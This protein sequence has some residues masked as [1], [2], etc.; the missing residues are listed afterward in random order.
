MAARDE[1]SK[2]L[3]SEPGLDQIRGD[4]LGIHALTVSRS[5]LTGQH[6]R[7]EDL[8]YI[9]DMDTLAK[10]LTWARER[11]GLTQGAL[12]KLSGV[13]QST[14]GNLEAGL[15]Q[16]ARKIVD[17]A[18]A[19]E[20]DPIWLANGKGAP[21]ANPPATDTTVADDD[22]FITDTLG[23]MPPGAKKVQ[24]GAG[25]VTVPIRA[26]KLRLQAG[27]TGYVEEPDMEID[28]GVFQVPEYVLEQLGTDPSRLM[29]MKI[30]GRSMEPSYVDG[31]IVLIDTTRNKPRENDCFAVNWNGELL[32]KCLIK[33]SD[34][35]C[36]YSFNR[37]Y[38]T[39]SVKSGQCSIIGMVVW[40]PERMVMGIL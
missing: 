14:I 27:I 18:S 24:V 33:K 8:Y 11:K 31:D 10:R 30:K 1:I 16:T 7:D 3:L 21:E 12:A 34:G 17:I 36:L 22:G 35:W 39:L 19:V 4:F 13:S 23:Q 26:V 9:R 29:V 6:Q 32:I 20:V 25:P 2:L 28:H 37:D 5:C 40:R 15:R 38:P